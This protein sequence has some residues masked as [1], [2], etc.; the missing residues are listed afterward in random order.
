MDAYRC[1][2]S[3]RDVRAYLDRPLEEAVLRRVL[4][5]G[6]RAG[7]AR[8]RQPW[9]FVVVTDRDLLRRLSRCGR[10]A[11]HLARAGAA[12]VIALDDARAL[13]DAGR[14]AQN[15]MLAA[16]SLGVAS[17]PA[18]LHHE[19]SARTVLA[20]PARFALAPVIALGYPHPRGRG[21]VERLV[22]A[23]ATGGGRKPLGTLVHWNRFG[24]RRPT[25][26]EPPV[27]DRLSSPDAPS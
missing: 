23:L 4:D 11:G 7:S 3:K 25:M 27:A 2:V 16:W 22:L 6:R 8:N 15:M 19:A 17:C 26:A 20:I 12:V 9:Q 1:V 13:F 21:R 10:F 24:A 5:A 14:C 18:T